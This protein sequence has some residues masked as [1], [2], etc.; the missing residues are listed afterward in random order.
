MLESSMLRARIDA[1]DRAHGAITVTRAH[2]HDQAGQTGH[3]ST[4]LKPAPATS[5]QATSGCGFLVPG[6][7]RSR[8]E[9]RSGI[10][11]RRLTLTAYVR[12]AIQ[13]RRRT[14]RRTTDRYPIVDW[15]SA[16]VLAPVVAILALCVLD[17]VLTVLLM[18]HGAVEANP[19][20][21]LFLPH[22]LGWFAT[23]KLLLTSAGV[24]VLV[25]CSR[26]RLFRTIPGELLLYGVLMCYIALIAYELQ[27]L[28]LVA[29]D[30]P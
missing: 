17:G 7:D 1:C 28:E 2:D 21:A 15:Y 22:S 24:C 23:V 3:M 29:T 19:V 11:R 9:R 12:G 10:E 4:I 25:A 20:M 27:L 8:R 16:R 6:V 14:G 26:M 18:S 13:P 30:V 5:S